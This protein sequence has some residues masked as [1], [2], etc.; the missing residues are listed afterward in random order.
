M[1]LKAEIELDKITIT[2]REYLRVRFPM[3][4]PHKELVKKLHNR[5]WSTTFQ[6]VYIP[7]TRKHIN[8]VF[9]TFKGVAWINME[10]INLKKPKSRS[11]QPKSLYQQRSKAPD[12][13]TITYYS[14]VIK[15]E[16]IL[17]LRR[18]SLNTLK[19]YKYCFRDFINH[20]NRISPETISTA[21]IKAFMLYLVNVKGIAASTQNQYINAIKFYYE[22]V[23]QR[24]PQNY[25]WERPKLRKKL[26]HVF[27]E[28]EIQL[29]LLSIQNIKHR[30][31]LLTI[32]SA[33]L[34]I[35]EL[36]N[37]KISDIMTSQACIHI[38][39]AKGKKDRYTL[40][41]N[42]LLLLLR[43]YYKEYQPDYW[44]FEGATGGQYSKSSIQKIFKRALEASGILKS[45]TVHTLRHS[46]ATHLLE[47]GVNLR[48]IQ[49]L[50]GH[51]S[52]K[53]TEI[54]THISNKDLS[55]ISSPLDF[56]II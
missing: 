1:K 36:V 55:K 44:L 29:L 2:G 38:K 56:L 16:E 25:H 41:S 12:N 5:K 14:E 6:C 31:I 17:T 15:L 50:L 32:Y 39:D 30:C 34:R 43:N 37:L 20:Y 33:G 3:Q 53:T 4:S 11:K 18:Y 52:S 10:K 19:T 27:T 45:A 22:Q 23:L 51:S 8:N 40:L 26:P 24:E 54:Y 46:F 47:R 42:Q 7:N 21:Q 13:N 28:E 48:Y 35:S 49:T 9:D